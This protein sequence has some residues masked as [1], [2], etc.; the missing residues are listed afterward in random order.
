MNDMSELPAAIV[1]SV[2]FICLF[3]SCSYDKYLTKQLEVKNKEVELKMK[4]EENKR[5]EI[6]HKALNPN[7]KEIL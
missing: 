5:M 7:H 6:L 3:G 2:L 1:I 4:Q